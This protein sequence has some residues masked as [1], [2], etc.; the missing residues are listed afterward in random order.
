[1]ISGRIAQDI[2]RTT[3]L[4]ATDFGVLMQLNESPD[5]CQRQR[6]L[7][8]FLEWDKTRLSHQLTRMANRGLIERKIESG[9]M[10]TICMTEEGRQL[11]RTAQPVHADGVR[12]YFLDHLSDDDLGYLQAVSRKL[13]KALLQC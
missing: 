11:L 8:T 1:M 12:K 2:S 7:Q 13:R 6:D 3:G 4:S 9:H 5:A 10:V